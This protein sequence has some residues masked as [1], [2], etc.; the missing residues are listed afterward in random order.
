MQDR[1]IRSS[2]G[3]VWLRL[4]ACMVSLINH[5]VSVLCS[6]NLIIIYIF[7]QVVGWSSSRTPT[8]FKKV[9]VRLQV[10]MQLTTKLLYGLRWDIIYPH[11][12]PWAPLTIR[13]YYIHSGI[14][15]FAFFLQIKSSRLSQNQMKCY[16]LL[17]LHVLCFC[18][19]L[20]RAEEHHL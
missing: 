19:A 14:F 6:P 2:F 20:H 15:F 13:I 10:S 16:H 18:L 8:F 7:L 9:R 12:G 4:R 5:T 3:Q 17:A 11:Y 1:F